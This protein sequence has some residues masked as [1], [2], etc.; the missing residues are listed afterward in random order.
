MLEIELVELMPEVLF[1]IGD[2]WKVADSDV[3]TELPVNEVENPV[4]LE[5][6][7]ELLTGR[8]DP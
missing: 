1:G 3:N 7:S 2:G 8:V 4:E 5:I 6:D